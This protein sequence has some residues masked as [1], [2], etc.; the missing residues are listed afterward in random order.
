MSSK[1][2]THFFLT[3][4]KMSKIA[5]IQSGDLLIW[6]RDKNSKL[7]N[8]LIKG[9]RLFTS[10]SYGHVAIAVWHNGELHFLE[11]TNPRVR[12]AV[13][14]ADQVIDGVL[15]VRVGVT[16]TSESKEFLFSKIGFKYSFL[17]VLRAYLGLTLKRDDRY[18]CAEIGNDFYALHGIDLQA[19][20]P[21]KLVRRLLEVTGA[22]ISR[23]M[24]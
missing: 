5:D 23:V 10:S 19:Y 15:C 1:A 22:S 3:K 18:Q 7:S 12:L 2:S 14:D 21:E 8:F 16:F 13:F 9:I 24:A 4:N 6:S 11:A 20:T 17:D